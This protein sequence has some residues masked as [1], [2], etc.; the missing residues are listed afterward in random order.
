MSSSFHPLA[1][2][3]SG[4]FYY[5]FD[6]NGEAVRTDSDMYK[7]LDALARKVGVLGVFSDWPAHGDVLRQL[8]GFQVINRINRLG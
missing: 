1:T 6:P 8:H 3:A 4:G 7:A 5:L 2:A